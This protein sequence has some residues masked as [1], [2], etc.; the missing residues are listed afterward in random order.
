MAT[1]N[2]KATRG[3]IHPNGFTLSAT[4]WQLKAA[5][6]L[7]GTRVFAFD[8]TAASNILTYGLAIGGGFTFEFS[9]T[10]LNSTPVKTGYDFTDC[11]E[12]WYSA[13]PVQIT[14]NLILG[15][16][17]STSL[18]DLGIQFKHTVGGTYDLNGNGA[19]IQSYLLFDVASTA[20]I[21]IRLLGDLTTT[22]YVI[23]ASGL[24][25]TNGFAFN[26]LGFNSYPS[27]P[28]PPLY[29]AAS[30]ITNAVNGTREQWMFGAINNLVPTGTGLLKMTFGRD[31]ITINS[32][33]IL[34]YGDCDFSSFTG[35]LAYTRSSVNIRGNLV[36][37]PAMAWSD[38]TTFFMDG[39]S[40]AQK[41]ITSNGATFGGTI[42]GP[43][44]LNIIANRG[45]PV[46]LNDDLKIGGG[47]HWGYFVL[48]TNAKF[49][50]N[51]HNMDSLDWFC[52]NNVTDVQ[53]GA[54]V[55]TLHGEGWTFDG[56]NNNVG[57]DAGT[58]T[59]RMVGD[60]LATNENKE[61][62]GNGST[63]YR[64]VFDGLVN[65]VGRFNGNWLWNSFNC[66]TLEIIGVPNTL[67]IRANQ[68]IGVHNLI[69]NGRA[70][71]IDAVPPVIEYVTIRSDSITGVQGHLVN[72]SGGDLSVEFAIIQDNSAT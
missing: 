30:G 72:L 14:A 21:V 10:T 65:E 67:N 26:A 40:V 57:F 44:E 60:F 38:P 41:S 22:N 47:T 66:D 45:F 29:G 69:L 39:S 33:L 52:G 64:V 17:M 28:V 32:N 61:F 3:G 24:I 48:G 25:D 42:A 23:L 20:D 63:Y 9:L 34:M 12:T 6:D 37:N 43:C 68:V 7:T 13:T 27:F 1:T 16:G 11:T 53:L 4:T 8:S 36:L 31:A 5:G 62:D 2:A 18:P 50:T 58:S 54:S 55:I 19:T 46:V 71:D 56:P 51:G 35:D 70:I 49:Y 15:A 59:I